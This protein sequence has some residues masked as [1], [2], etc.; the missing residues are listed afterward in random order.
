MPNTKID[1]SSFAG[2]QTAQ[3]GSFLRIHAR[4]AAFLLL[5]SL[6]QVSPVTGAVPPT[7]P[8][9]AVTDL[10]IAKEVA[11]IVL[12]HDKEHNWP[13]TIEVFLSKANLH[14]RS[15]HADLGPVVDS[16]R[17]FSLLRTYG[18][19]SKDTY[20]DVDPSLYEGNSDMSKVRPYV[21]VIRNR[22]SVTIPLPPGLFAQSS[23]VIPSYTEIQF[24]FFFPFNGCQTHR[25]VTW[26]PLAPW[27]TYT[28]HF[29]MCDAAR[30][31]G[32]VEAVA[33]LINPV[34]RQPLG[35]TTTRHGTVVYTPWEKIEARGLRPMVYS[36]WA[37]HAMYT[38]RDNVSLS[39]DFTPGAVLACKLL[40]VSYWKLADFPWGDGKVWDGRDYKNN[41]VLQDTNTPITKYLG[42]WGK[43]GMDNRAAY[44]PL[45]WGLDNNNNNRDIV[46]YVPD[47]AVSTCFYTL[48]TGGSLLYD[49]TSFV[50]DFDPT[51][52]FD[53]IGVEKNKLVGDGTDWYSKPAWISGM[54]IQKLE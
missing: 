5:A 39:P 1:N 18:L 51:G 15:D 30:H 52:T 50:S 41:I 32:D 9:T 31:E 26:R 40:N 8:T 34:T 21:R 12:F 4:V 24:W 19:D 22:P 27:D 10:D 37:S 43:V 6:A 53:P 46:P 7:L 3:A 45:E 23:L 48:E 2:S 44:P 13:A 35:I 36:A 54:A 17:L 42:R 47:A 38:K 29:Q 14:R 25:M 28:R 16:N 11:P 49:L 20:L 33:V